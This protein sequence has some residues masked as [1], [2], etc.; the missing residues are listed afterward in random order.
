M[1]APDT[2]GRVPAAPD[3]LLV[4]PA[5]YLD[6]HGYAHGQAT[7]TRGAV[8]SDVNGVELSIDG[9]EVYAQRNEANVPWVLVSQTDSGDRTATIS[10]LVVGWEYAFK[11]RATNDGT[12]GVF[13]PPFVVLVPDDSRSS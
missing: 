5:A 2:D 1:P 13:S 12:K 9:Y 7:L 10:P 8:A 6:E 4:Q 3:R 11:V